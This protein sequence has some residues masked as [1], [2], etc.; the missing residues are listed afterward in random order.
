[1][2]LEVSLVFPIVPHPERW[3]L[4]DEERVPESELQNTIARYLVSVFMAWANRTG[5]SALV[6]HNM[7]LRWDRA[8]SRVG[9]DPDVMLAEPRPP[10]GWKGEGLCTWREGESAPRVCVEVVRENTAE[11]DYSEGPKKYAASGTRELWVFDPEGHG[12]AHM[13]GPVVL[14]V[15]RR[16]NR[17]EFKCVYSGDGPAFS[18]EMKAWLVVEGQTLAI[19]DDAKAERRWPT[20]VE[21]GRA[22]ERALV[23]RERAD[24]RDRIERDLAAALERAK[25]AERALAALQSKTKAPTKPSPTKKP[26]AK[27]R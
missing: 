14:R 8:H 27:K 6:A 16:V 2:A 11:K 10:A 5:V 25:A 20:E 13:G 26:K 7:A 4:L 19:A 1:M 3:V 23:E 15:Y 17:R 24:E 9:V 21:Q 18:R 22:E 12:P